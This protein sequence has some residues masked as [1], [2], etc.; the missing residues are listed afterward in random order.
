M[1]IKILESSANNI[2]IEM[3]NGDLNALHTIMEKW[4]FSD[5]I[6]AIRFAMATLYITEKGLLYKKEEDGSFSLLSPIM[7][8]K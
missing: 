2:K 4:K 8:E 1:A 6:S 5:E 7:N 3:D